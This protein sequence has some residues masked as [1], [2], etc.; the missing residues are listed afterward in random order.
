M[1]TYLLHKFPFTCMIID[2]DLSL[3]LTLRLTKNLDSGH[4]LI[5]PLTFR[6]CIVWMKNITHWALQQFV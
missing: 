2:N 4:N 1:I 5:Q 3:L 6:C